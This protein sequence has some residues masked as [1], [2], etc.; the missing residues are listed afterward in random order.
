MSRYVKYLY[1]Y[2]CE[3]V[4]LS[5]PQELQMAIDSNKRDRRHSENMD[6]MSPQ[7]QREMESTLSP[8]V[9]TTPQGLQLISSPTMALPHASVPPYSGG[10]I[11]AGGPGGTQLVQVTPHGIPIVMPAPTLPVS[12]PNQPHPPPLSSQSQSSSEDRDDVQ[13]HTSGESLEPP[14]KRPALQETTHV[15]MGSSGTRVPY[16]IHQTSTGNFIMTHGSVTSTGAPQLIQMNPHGQL[17]IVLPTGGLSTVRDSGTAPQHV[18]GKTTCHPSTSDGVT[19]T[20]RHPV[21]GVAGGVVFSQRGAAPHNA[22]NLFQMA[23]HPNMPGLIIPQPITPALPTQYTAP[24]HTATQTVVNGEERRKTEQDKVV[25]GSTSAI[26]MPFANISIQPGKMCW[27]EFSLQNCYTR[28]STWYVIT[29]SNKPAI[30]TLCFSSASTKT[31]GEEQNG[32]DASLLVT[33][34]INNT[35]YQGVL[36][37]KP[38]A[39][40]S[41]QR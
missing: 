6:F 26:K 30:E 39:L 25:G 29:N 32:V 40:S 36:F 20:A 15:Q 11:V 34:E 12:A 41:P 27:G 7:L 16:S 24:Q 9:T 2:E 1:P 19:V 33:L 35:V 5:D 14:A 22:R 4:K 3:K 13:S 23:H 17:P 18:N 8:V 21:G 38:Q 28:Y 37:A 10:F 31:E